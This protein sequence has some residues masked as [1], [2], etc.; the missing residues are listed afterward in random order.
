[1]TEQRKE[2]AIKYIMSSLEDGYLDLGLH[3]Q[4]EL[5][6]IKEAMRLLIVEEL[7]SYVG[8]IPDEYVERSKIVHEDVFKDGVA[9]LTS[10]QFTKIYCN[11]CSTQRCAGINSEWFD[12]CKFKEYLSR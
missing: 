5:T 9:Y 1:M 10:E 6:V 11:N 4:D 7:L 2:E 3:N 12:G 8:K